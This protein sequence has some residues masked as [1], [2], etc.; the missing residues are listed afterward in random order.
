ME[1]WFVADT[2]FSHPNI[3]KHCNRQWLRDGDLDGH[4]QWVSDEIKEARTQEMNAGLLK[5]WNEV[6][7]PKDLV[8]IVGDFA[9][10]DHRRWVNELNGKKVFLIGSHDKMPGDALDLFKAEVPVDGDI[11]SVKQ[12]EVLKTMVQFREVHWLL[13]RE[14]CGQWMTLCHWPMR[15]WQGKPHGSVCVVGHTHGRMRETRPGEC[16]GG[17]ILDVG[18]D[19][20]HRPITFGEVM[21]EMRNKKAMMGDKYYG[22]DEI[23]N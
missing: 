15:T 8:Y 20:W 14:I 6:V 13:N 7:D 11:E 1:T 2:H 10:K 12:A 21:T 19:I 17:L 4:R 18:W 5:S 22:R 3:L 23:V 9:W 16:G